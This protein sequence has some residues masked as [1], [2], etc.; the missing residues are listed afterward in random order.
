MYLEVKKCL[1][2]ESKYINGIIINKMQEKL[3]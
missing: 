1:S 2:I 3:N